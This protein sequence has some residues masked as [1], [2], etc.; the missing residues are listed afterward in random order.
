MNK[1]FCLLIML[2]A[3][4]AVLHAQSK[5]KQNETL[6]LKLDSVMS[7]YA[8]CESQ[9]A[10]MELTLDGKKNDSVRLTANIEELTRLNEL[11]EA[12][13]R[14]S[15]F[16]ISSLQ[17]QADSL[18]NHIL[19][20]MPKPSIS[21]EELVKYVEID[22]WCSSISAA[23][24]DQFFGMSNNQEL[25]MTIRFHTGTKEVA[26]ITIGVSACGDCWGR[27]RFYFDKMNNLIREEYD[28]GC[29]YEDPEH[30]T[31][32]LFMSTLIQNEYWENYPTRINRCFNATGPIVPKYLYAEIKEAKSGAVA[33][34][35]SKIEATSVNEFLVF[36]CMNM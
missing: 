22:E 20:E 30:P 29:A 19:L 13:V 26:L 36:E 2:Q 9:I 35:W 34:S 16:Q 7:I 14:S 21:D 4:S 18:K 32:S 25:G 31:V 17:H 10:S 6:A 33:N 27:Y 23:P 5:K 15:R 1:L 8:Q 28:E 12:S 24:I 3:G 11:L